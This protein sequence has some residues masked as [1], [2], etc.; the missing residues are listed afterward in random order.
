MASPSWG[1]AGTD[2]FGNHGVGAECPIGASRGAAAGAPLLRFD[3]ET[4]T[5]TA[6]E[7]VADLTADDVARFEI[8]RRAHLD[9]M[10]IFQP[11]AIRPRADLPAVGQCLRQADADRC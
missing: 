1:L 7:A 9:R 11:G 4:E 3:F 5:K 6:G 8:V 10:G 2:R